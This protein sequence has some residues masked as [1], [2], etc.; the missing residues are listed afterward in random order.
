MSKNTKK[1]STKI[2]SLA[3][4]ILS[5]SSSSKTAKSLAASALSQVNR[6][7]QTGRKLED[8][9]SIVIKSDKYN[10]QTKRLAGS[11]LSQSNKKR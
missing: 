6:S 5:D 2:A 8:K 4:E 10:K 11:I 1:T 9:A 3:S 7:K